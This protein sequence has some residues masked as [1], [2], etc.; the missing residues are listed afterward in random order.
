M[1][2]S[3]S[4][5]IVPDLFLNRTSLV[6][7]SVGQP[8]N[9]YTWFNNGQELSLTT[10]SGFQFQQIIS[11]HHLSKYHQILNIPLSASGTFTCEVSDV[12]GM[13]ASRSLQLNCTSLLNTPGPIPQLA[14]VLSPRYT[15]SHYCV[16]TART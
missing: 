5:L 13:T 4:V 1:F 2:I 12:N 16:C 3:E 7:V 9:N 11:D 8:V 15:Y 10:G 6:C 14:A